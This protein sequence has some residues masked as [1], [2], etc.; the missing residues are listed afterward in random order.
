MAIL[1]AI[2]SYGLTL[3]PERPFGNAAA[4]FYFT[5]P[6]SYQ[7]RQVPAE[8]KRRFQKKSTQAAVWERAEVGRGIGDSTSGAV[9]G[10]DD[11]CRLNLE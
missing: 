10:Y 11:S 8:L 1:V 3:V 9:F 4:T 5:Q 2:L 6:I 7:S